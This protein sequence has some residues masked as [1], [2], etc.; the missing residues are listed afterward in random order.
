MTSKSVRG[1]LIG[2]KEV[3]ATGGKLTEDISHWT[4]EVYAQVAAATTADVTAAADAAAA[5][6]PSWSKMLPYERRKI[7]LRAADILESRSEAAIDVMAQEV[8]AVRPWAKVNVDTCIEILRESAAAVTHAT[9]QL[10]ATNIEG[11]YSMAVRLPY[12]V[13]GAISPWN[14]AYILGIRSIAIP[15][16]MGNTVVMKPSEDAPI[17]CGLYLA[18]LLIEAGLPPGALNVVSNDIKDA[19]PIVS[20][21]V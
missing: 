21:L 14:A 11:A 18:D 19:G 5:A 3:P 8:G 9:G 10:L 16:A 6:F 7:F 2:G 1:L 4:A 20:A 13:V 17:A 15:L 12:G